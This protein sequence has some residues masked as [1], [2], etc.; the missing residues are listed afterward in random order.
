[1]FPGTAEE[2]WFGF[3]NR[4]GHA[5]REFYSEIERSNKW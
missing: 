5:W 2:K 4:S 1:M 3:I